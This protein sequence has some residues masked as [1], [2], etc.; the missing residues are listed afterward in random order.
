MVISY[1]PYIRE[2]TPSKSMPIDIFLEGIRSG[3]WEDHAHRVRVIADKDERQKEKTSVPY[4]TLSG[5]FS[6]RNIKGLLTHSGLLAID[7]D[8][9]DDIDEVKSRVCCDPYVYAC[10]TS[11]SGRGLCVIMKINPEKHLDSFLGVQQHLFIEYQLVVDT[12]GK[13]VSRARYVSYDPDVFINEGAKKFAKY[14][15]KEKPIQVR[16]VVFVQTDFDYII[17]QI[18]DRRIDITGNYPQWLKCCFA[19]CDKLGEGGRSY[20][21]VISQYSALYD[22][23]IADK[24]YDN[25][26]K[27]GKSGVTIASFY[28]L[29][30]ESGVVIASERTKLIAQTA[31]LG[32][33]GGRSK[34]SV[35][36]ML[37]EMDGIAPVDT[38]DIVGQVFDEGAESAEAETAVE[39]IRIW[40]FQNHDLRFNEVTGLLED[41]GVLV[42]D[43]QQ[44]AIEL[45][46][47]KSFP[48]VDFAI[49]TKMLHSAYVPG[50][51]PIKDFFKRY[52]GVNAPGN[53]DRL[54]GAIHSPQGADHVRYFGTKW[55]VGMVA[56][57]FEE[58]PPLML[59]LCGEKHGT[60]KTRF[61]KDLLPPE[62]KGYGTVKSLADMSNETFRRD[63]EI[64]MSKYWLIYDDEMGGKSKRDE[65]K[66]KALL[67]LDDATHRPSHGRNEKRYRRLCGFGA[68]SN[69]LRVIGWDTGNR[70]LLPIEIARIDFGQ[71]NSVSRIELFM[72]AYGLYRAG[73][74]YRVLGD[75]IDRLEAVGEDFEQVNAEEELILQRYKPGK[76][77]DAV[78]MTI[79]DIRTALQLGAKETFSSNK[80]AK[81]MQ[82]IGSE[83]VA[84]KIDGLSLRGYWL[85]AR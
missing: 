67:S 36:R 73:F 48:K 14:L 38:Q 18:V 53:I 59:I 71:L 41:K 9:L 43:R 49:I 26:L 32:K 23:K 81:V 16:E 27:S 44:F 20:F 25:C 19:L 83:R 21:H 60:G 85:V 82:E 62:L 80:I 22:T 45:D 84:K 11:I 79:T 66:I 24:Q 77:P 70:R 57:V 61:F 17:E 13:D 33:K 72:E 76:Y 68:T 35:I 50:Y 2:L 39:Q 75:D 10:F 8:D 47:K 3:L 1:Y 31:T 56:G 30:K 40:L 46:M 42:D 74:D 64:A 12:S 15:K 28:Y 29:A 52:E 58:A 5:V 34:E 54:F 4:V 69:D 7:L 6:Q 55:L 63:L 65:K 51:H 78:F 37:D